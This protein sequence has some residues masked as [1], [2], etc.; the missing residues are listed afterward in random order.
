MQAIINDRGRQYVVHDGDSLVVD[1][2]PEI[3]PGG[4][5]LFDRVL[6]VGQTFG[7]PTVEGAVVKG[8][9]DEHF[10]D[11]KILVEKFRRRKDYKRRAGH[12]QKLTRL[13]ITSISQ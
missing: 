1:H 11:K 4:E 3:E 7:K 5:V 12:R 6:A 10:R 13:K 8:V 9:V 2:M